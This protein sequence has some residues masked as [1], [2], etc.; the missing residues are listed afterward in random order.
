M[1]S[2]LGKYWGLYAVGATIQCVVI[3]AVSVRVLAPTNTVA[4]W[5]L[6]SIFDS[7][8]SIGGPGAFEFITDKAIVLGATIFTFIIDWAEVLSIAAVYI[9][10]IP[11]IMLIREAHRHQALT[12]V[13]TWAMD[14]IMKLTTTN[15]QPSAT[16]KL[17]EWQ[18]RLHSITEDSGTI[19]A[20]IRAIGNGLNSKMETAVE[21]VA[22]LEDSFNNHTSPEELTGLLKSAVMAFREISVTTSQILTKSR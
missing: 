21:N 4:K 16:K 19:L 3:L 5:L 17:E 15:S 12:R 6:N 2:L 10:S 11:S 20:D 1:R 14:A 22:K 13:N 7:T 18:Q 8:F 9:I